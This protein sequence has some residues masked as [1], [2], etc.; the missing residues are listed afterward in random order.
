MSR[1][2]QKEEKEDDT[3]KPQPDLIAEFIHTYNPEWG[4]AFD[5]GANR[6]IYT[7]HLLTASKSV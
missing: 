4:T 6:G 2:Q 1:Y 5:I 7:S 3:T